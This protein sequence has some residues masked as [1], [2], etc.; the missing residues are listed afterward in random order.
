MSTLEIPRPELFGVE[1]YV[2]IQ[3]TVKKKLGL[4]AFDFTMQAEGPCDPEMLRKLYGIL[5]T[6]AQSATISTG[7]L[8]QSKLGGQSVTSSSTSTTP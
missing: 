7:R 2:V 5:S 4:K 1:G 3:L 8:L 6:L